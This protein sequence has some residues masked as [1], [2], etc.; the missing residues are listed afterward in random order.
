VTYVVEHAAALADVRLA[1]TAVT[2]SRSTTTYTEATDVASLATTTVAGYALRV[3]GDPERYRALSLVESAA[4][5]L[6]FVPTTY[7][8]R[9]EVG[10]TL[11]WESA[12]HTVRDVSP[13]A[14]DGTPILARVVVGR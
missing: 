2:F 14:P 1:G 6:L 8:D 3:R 13:L 9:P 12:T 7:G 11:T 10:D 4:P 5:T